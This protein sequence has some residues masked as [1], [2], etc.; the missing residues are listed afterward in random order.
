MNKIATLI[1]AGG[2]GSRLGKGPKALLEINGKTLLEIILDR[3]GNDNFAIIVSNNNYKDILSRYPDLKNK[4]ILQRDLPYMNNNGPAKDDKG[5]DIMGPNGNGECLKLLYCSKIYKEWRNNDITHVSVVPIDNYKA[6]SLG[7]NYDSDY[8]IYDL[9]VKAIVKQPNESVGTII[10]NKEKNIL[11][12]VEYMNLQPNERNYKYGYSGL[13]L[14]SCNW[15][16]KLYC[17]NTTNIPLHFVWKEVDGRSLKKAE[18]FIID[19]F[20]LATTWKI[21]EIDRNKE[22]YPIKSPQ[23]LNLINLNH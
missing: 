11:E 23:D 3:I 16:D 2:S 21:Q 20:P 18:Y 1:L 15:I 17:N 4:L 5:N 14:C 10:V 6:L 19:L 9:V 7:H 8:I 22:F 13:C 12:I